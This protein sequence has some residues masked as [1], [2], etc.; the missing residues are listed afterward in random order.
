MF[1][2]VNALALLERVGTHSHILGLGISGEREENASSPGFEENCPRKLDF[3]HSGLVGRQQERRTLFLISKLVEQHKGRAI[4]ITGPSGSGKSALEHAFMMDLRKKNIPCKAISASEI[5]SSSMGKAEALMQAIRETLGICVQETYRVLEGEVVEIQTDRERA[6]SGRVILKTTEMEAAYTFGVGIMQSM[7]AERIEPG[8]IITV[9]KTTGS[10]KKKGKS[11][12]QARDYEAIGPMGQYI[13]CPD[14]E[15]LRT[16]M[17]THTV[18]FHDIDVLNSKQ[19]ALRESTGEIPVEVRES[20]NTTMKDWVEEGRGTLVTGALFINEAELL[21]S[22][23]Y[24]FLNTLSE[25][26]VSP[27]VV[28]SSDGDAWASKNGK[29]A[30]KYGISADF[31]SRVLEIRLG[32]YSKDEIKRIIEIRVN[33]ECDKMKKDGVAALTELAVEHGLRYA[34]NLL[35]ALDVYSARVGKD[36]GSEE[37]KEVSEIFPAYTNPKK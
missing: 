21:D 31:Y 29:G 12:G 4:L 34:F 5:V 30:E 15:V 2:K 18:T 35:S 33:E 27:V 36:V 13:P 24:A 28:L 1:E 16:Q 26:S 11:L 37:V 20:V 8:D 14:G 7:H 6:S 9:N 3:E 17:E 22:E 19:S 32:E 10:V 25:I 23:C